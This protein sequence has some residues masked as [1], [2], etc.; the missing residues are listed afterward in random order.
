MYK[1]I[2]HWIESTKKHSYDIKWNK[3]IYSKC[4]FCCSKGDPG[5]YKNIVEVYNRYYLTYKYLIEKYNNVIWIDYYKLLDKKNVK[6]YL[7]D[8]LS[9][10]N[11]KDKENDINYILNKPS[12]S[13]GKPVNNSEEALNKKIII[14]N[15]YKNSKDKK[16]IDNILDKSIVDFYR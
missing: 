9:P 11:I 13:H 7:D 5:E 14:N 10:F 8:N 12:K 15:K 16:F 3:D 6:K 1:P 4:N 2:Y